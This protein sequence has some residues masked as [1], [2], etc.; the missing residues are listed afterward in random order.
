[1]IGQLRLNLPNDKLMKTLILNK[2]ANSHQGLDLKNQVNDL[3]DQE[4]AETFQKII[5]SEIGFKI[6]PL[7]SK[8]KGLKDN[9]ILEDLQEVCL[10]VGL[11]VHLMQ[12]VDLVMSDSKI[13]LEEDLV[14]I[15]LQW[16]ENMT[17]Q[18]SDKETSIGTSVQGLLSNVVN[19]VLE[20]IGFKIVVETLTDVVQDQITSHQEV[21]IL[22]KLNNTMAL[23]VLGAQLKKT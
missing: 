23:Q 9:L 5:I 20:M 7:K 19:A 16:N 4:K 1:M 3:T 6:D 12:I 17:S 2:R 14:L 15:V 8:V 22:T 18:I 13:T 11:I 21:I 10:I